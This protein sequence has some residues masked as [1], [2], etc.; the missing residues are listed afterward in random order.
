MGHTL[1]ILIVIPN[2]VARLLVSVGSA[3]AS[4]AFLG[5]INVVLRSS[6]DPGIPRPRP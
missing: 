5:C 3:M 4:A 1:R 6:D 2:T